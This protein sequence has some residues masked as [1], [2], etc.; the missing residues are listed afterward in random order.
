MRKVQTVSST[1]ISPVEMVATKRGQKVNVETN[2]EEEM[3]LTEPILGHQL[4][5]DWPEDKLHAGMQKE[6]ESMRSFGVYGKLQ[7]IN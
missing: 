3:R 7:Q 2:E 4:L 5:S 6:M 1:T